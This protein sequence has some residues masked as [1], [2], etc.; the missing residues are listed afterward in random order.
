MEVKIEAGDEFANA[1]YEKVCKDIFRDIG[2]S[3]NI[4]NAYMYCNA[5]EHIFIIS[6]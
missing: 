4:D 5:A 6:V 2:L 1:S 3:S